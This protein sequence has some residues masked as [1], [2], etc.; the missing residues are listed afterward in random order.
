MSTHTC[1]HTFTFHGILYQICPIVTP[2]GI[3]RYVL[4]AAHLLRPREPDT[5]PPGIGVMKLCM[6]GAAEEPMEGLT[7]A[8]WNP[9]VCAVLCL[10]DLYVGRKQRLRLT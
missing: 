6:K 1:T 2:I 10:V 5:L 8:S 4:F 7:G 9:T 3:V